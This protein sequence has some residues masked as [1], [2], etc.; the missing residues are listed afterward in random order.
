MSEDLYYPAARNFLKR[1]E[2]D[3]SN[4]IVDIMVSVMRTRDGVGFMGGSF[5]QS[6]VNNNLAEAVLRS[7]N[8][9]INHLK[10]FVLVLYNCYP[11]EELEYYKVE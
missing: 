9:C 7:D 4:H 3:A 10:T 11:Q 8:D 6:I 5:V 2:I 1:Y